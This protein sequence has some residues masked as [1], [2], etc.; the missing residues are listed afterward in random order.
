LNRRDWDNP[1][2]FTYKE[3]S[4]ELMEQLP[5]ELIQENLLSEATWYLETEKPVFFG[6][7]WLKG[8][9]SLFRHNVCC[10]DYSVA[11]N[12]HLVAYRWGGEQTLDA[13]KLISVESR[14]H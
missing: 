8:A 11:K 10:L 6:H 4:V 12:G 2:G 7:Y 14:S 1:K 5:E 9:I 3:Y 13:A